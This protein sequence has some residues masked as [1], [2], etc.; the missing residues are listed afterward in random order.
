MK[1]FYIAD[2]SL[3]NKSAYSQHVIKM[4]DAFGQN[5][6]D[7]TILIVPY[8]KEKINFSKLKKRFML[9]SIHQLKIKSILKT[10][11]SNFLERLIF[12][13]KASIFLKDKRKSL[14]ITRSLYASIFLSLLRINHFLEIH[15]ELKSFTKFCLIGLNFINSKYII[16]IIFISKAL[17]KFYNINNKKIMILHDGTDPKN[18]KKGK[19]ITRI[20]TATYIGS[21]YKGRGIELILKLAK[22]FNKI[23]FNLYG[24]SNKLSINNTK[25]LKI[26]NHIDYKKVPNILSKSDILLMPYS[27]DVSI[28]ANNINTANYCSPLK[29]FD[30]LASGRIIISSKLDGICEVLKH[31]K[32]S[33]IVNKY[34]YESWKKVVNNLLENKFNINKISENS[35]STSKKYSWKNRANKILTEYKKFNSKK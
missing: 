1:V 24:K 30:Y 27:N 33:L 35:L 26:F 22:N 29:M 4:C 11:I 34:N 14:I 19:K 20:K 13:F 12:G 7:N 17:K 23:N 15:T 9:N 3:T 28:N 6:T 8:E 25:N 5:I 10:K 16:K 31:K 21:F 18:F 32:N 2:T